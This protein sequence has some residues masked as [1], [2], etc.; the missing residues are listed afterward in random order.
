M[1]RIEWHVLQLLRAN[2]QDL[3]R[4]QPQA[5]ARVQVEAEI[6]TIGV[7]AEL[8]GEAVTVEIL[9]LGEQLVL[10]LLQAEAESG[11]DVGVGGAGLV[12]LFRSVSAEKR[13]R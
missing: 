1:A 5:V 12:I 8:V 2:V 6:P 4:I 13:R 10:P 9:Q 7:G 11:I 3:A